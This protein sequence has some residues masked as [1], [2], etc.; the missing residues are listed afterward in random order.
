MSTGIQ[1]PS[2]PREFMNIAVGIKYQM[3]HVN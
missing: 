1:A 2:G 3:L